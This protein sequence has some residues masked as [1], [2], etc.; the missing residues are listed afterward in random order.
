MKTIQP[1]QFRILAITPVTNGVGF[2]VLEG[3]DTLVDW[4]VK[5]VAEK[6]NAGSLANV[7]ELIGRYRPDVLVMEN[8]SAEGS[9][10]CPRI[11]KLFPQLIGL[12]K[13]NNLRTELFSRDQLTK[14]FIPDGKGTKHAVAQIIA[15]KFPLQLETKLPPKRKPWMHEHYQMAIFDA[16]ALAWTQRMKN[17]VKT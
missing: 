17:A 14:F 9:R 4:G 6:K 2:A 10:R 13:A 16:V 15:K 3:K 12:A 8:A 7:K 11:R 5:N 1:D